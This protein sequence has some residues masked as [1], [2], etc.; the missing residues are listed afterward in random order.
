MS[1]GRQTQRERGKFLLQIGRQYEDAIAIARLN[2]TQD[3]FDVRSIAGLVF[4]HLHFYHRGYFADLAQK[5]SGDWIFGTTSTSKRCSPGTISLKSSICLSG[6]SLK[7]TNPVMFPP[8][9]ARLYVSI[10]DGI[11]CVKKYNRYL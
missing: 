3:T 6:S 10:R 8:G 2:G 1:L 5:A 4:D 7:P 11:R 9:R